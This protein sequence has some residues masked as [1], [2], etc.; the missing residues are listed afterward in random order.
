MHKPSIPRSDHVIKAFPELRLHHWP[1]RQRGVSLT[2]ADQDK[3]QVGDRIG[4]S[5]QVIGKEVTSQE[6][7]CYACKYTRNPCRNQCRNPGKCYENCT[8]YGTKYEFT[9]LCDCGTV[10]VTSDPFQSRKCLG[11]SQN[12]TDLRRFLYSLVDLAA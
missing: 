12:V 10:K 4:L 7:G 11:H 1:H 5:W 3:I 6:L 9:L 2:L 8:R